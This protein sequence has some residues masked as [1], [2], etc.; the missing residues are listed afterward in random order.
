MSGMK[1]VPQCFCTTARKAQAVLSE[2]ENCSGLTHYTLLI[3]QA[4]AMDRQSQQCENEKKVKYQP[5]Y[6][7][8]MLKMNSKY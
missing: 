7:C 6:A 5:R 4:E 1:P 8:D 2:P 3:S